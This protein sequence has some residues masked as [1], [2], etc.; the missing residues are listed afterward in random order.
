VTPATSA[1]GSS[2]DRRRRG[3]AAPGGAV[4]AATGTESPSRPLDIRIGAEVHCRDGKA[5]QVERVVISPCRR[6]VTHLIVGK[7]LVLHK[8][9]VVPIERVR[10]ADEQHVDLDLTLDQ[11]NELPEYKV[12]DYVAPDPSW[13]GSLPYDPG[14]TVLAVDPYTL[15]WGPSTPSLAGK[16]VRHARLGV[17]RDAAIVPRGSPVEGQDGKVGEVDHVLLDPRQ[18]TI[19]RL[20]VRRGLLLHKDV[21]I[22]IDWVADVD[23]RGVILGV[24]RAALEQLPPY[25]PGRLDELVANDVRDA[26]RADSRTRVAPIAVKGDRGDVELSG[27]TR[28]GAARLAASEVVRGMPRVLQTRSR[29]TVAGNGSARSVDSASGLDFLWVEAFVHRAT[30]L[31]VDQQQAGEIVGHAERKLRDFFELAEDTAL[32]NGREVIY[33]NDLPLTRGLRKTLAEFGASRAT[34]RQPRSR[35]TSPTWA[36]SVASIRSFEPSCRACSRRSCWWTQKS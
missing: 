26:L 1:T 27:S 18:H 5:G 28:D 29:R 12:V 25:E 20:V 34:S 35:R 31:H 30:G 6:Q 4:A 2:T 11:L 23:D 22:P 16:V 33:T 19:T 14:V 15:A 32:R 21:A 9:I 13:H 36:S 24:S 10:F 3:T 7:G 8:D 17:P